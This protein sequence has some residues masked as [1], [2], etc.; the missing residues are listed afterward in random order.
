MLSENLFRIIN[1]YIPSQHIPFRFVSQNRISLCSTNE[2]SRLLRNINPPG[3]DPLYKLYRN[4][5]PH[6]L[7]FLRK[8]WSENGYRL[9]LFWSGIGYGFEEN[10]GSE[11]STYL[12]FEFQVSKKERVICQF[13]MDFK[14]ST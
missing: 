11:R 4:V 9:C 7:G 10:Y 1:I 6:R 5:P 3:G 14:K 8:F 12:L 2:V 13:E